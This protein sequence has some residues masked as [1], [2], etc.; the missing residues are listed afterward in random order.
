ML[1]LNSFYRPLKLHLNLL[2]NGLVTLAVAEDPIDGKVIHYGDKVL[3]R[4]NAFAVYF[5]LITASLW[6]IIVISFIVVLLINGINKLRGK[7][8]S[9]LT[10]N[11]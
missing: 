7:K 8:L 5:Q 6:I 4:T 1:N 11:N 2:D 9:E 3:K 10:T